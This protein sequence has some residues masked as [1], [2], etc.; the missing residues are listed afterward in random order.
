MII[1]FAAVVLILIALALAMILPPLIRPSAALKQTVARDEITL[2]IFKDQQAEL[3]N[4][5]KNGII[6]E[7]QYEQAKIDLERNMLE[8]LKD[9][10]DLK[11]GEAAVAARPV[12]RIVPGIV[13]MFIPVLAIAF[14]VTYGA[15]T[16]GFEPEKATPTV[17]ADQH[18][19]SLEGMLEQLLAR[20][21]A[22]P[23]DG[24]G[25]F[26]LARTYQF[27]KRYGDAVK[28]FEKTVALGGGQD[29]TVLASYADAIAMASNRTVTPKSIAL[30]EKAIQ[31]DPN[32]VKALWLAGTAAY[33]DK[34][35]KKA[36]QY[37]SHLQGVLAPD[38]EEL[39][40]ITANVAEVKSL[41]GMTSGAVVPPMAM[42]TSTSQQPSPTASSPS[43]G[44]KVTGIVNLT[45]DLALKA[46]LD[47]TL[48]IFAR[49]AQG[50]KMPLAILRKQ[51]RDLP[52]K[53][54]LDD[55]MAMSAQMKL[56]SFSRIIVGARISKTGDAMKQP[57]D[58]EGYS[59]VLNVGDTA[60]VN[61]EIN[62]IVD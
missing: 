41:L 38:S 37:W 8:D 28:A 13:G 53:F 60:P 4:D 47:D 39:A 17:T 15:G 24:E 33:Q 59:A 50:P 2:S 54:T 56:S 30:L 3:D 51:V 48:F 22:N 43:G 49:A 10:K 14:Y 55:S 57:G 27:M 62:S 32:H 34:K 7:D 12:P 21:D 1:G 45:D 36:L 19:Q 52:V 61:V 5:F 25:W 35:Y 29:A 46:E 20:L 23:N 6:T 44:A 9:L 18:S 26:M 31:I 42:P 16:N 58:L 11:E 40:T